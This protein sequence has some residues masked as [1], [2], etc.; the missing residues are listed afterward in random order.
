M[1]NEDSLIRFLTRACT[2]EEL[3]EVENWISTD[4]ANA[5]W[6]FAKRKKSIVRT[7]SRSWMRYA[8]AA[9]LCLLPATSISSLLTSAQRRFPSPPTSSKCPYYAILI[10]KV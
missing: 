7:L 8:A 3:L 10:K 9:I 6:L 4:A 1:M 2:R 5:G